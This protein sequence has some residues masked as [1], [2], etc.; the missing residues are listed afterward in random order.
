MGKGQATNKTQ[1]IQLFYRKI[2]K[3]ER[4]LA[5]QESITHEIRTKSEDYELVNRLN[6][7]VNQGASLPQILSQLALGTEK[8]FK[9]YGVNIYLLNRDGKR[10]VLQR[11][12]EIN[13]R[14]KQIASGFRI[15]IPD[16]IEIDVNK[17]SIHKRIL[18]AKK[19]RIIRDPGQITQIIAGFLKSKSIIKR[20]RSLVE[21]LKIKA[22]VW[23]PLQV[24]GKTIG[25]MD[26]SLYENVSSNIRNRIESIAAVVNSILKYAIINQRLKQSQQ[27]L[28]MCFDCACDIIVW[29]NA[30]GII[31]RI[32]DRV[33]DI[34][35]YR[36]E[37]FIGKNLSALTDIFE[38]DIGI[39]FK[40]FREVTASGKMKI[41]K[42]ANINISHMV[43]K[44][45]NGQEVHIEARTS[46]VKEAD[47]IIGY[48]SII[49]DMTEQKTMENALRT[50]E[51]LLRDFM[52]SANIGFVMFDREFNVTEVNQFIIDKFRLRKEDVIGKNMLDYSLG[53]MET[54]RLQMYQRVIDSGK[55]YTVEVITPDHLGLYRLLLK[56]FRLSNGI[57]MIVEFEEDSAGTEEEHSG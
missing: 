57:G 21:F 42:D 6:A 13:R 8:L 33:K 47:K 49:R 31:E 10:L 26:L 46:A 28:Q 5:A 11:N 3:F 27:E 29:I 37:E 39:L 25:L 38:Q 2:V 22:V 55:P 40:E 7:L 17:S 43:L 24:E 20:I 41:C 15:K 4:L 48:L 52:E 45:R 16:T 34:L 44:K 51:E 23:V 14:I 9:G 56:V 35:G 1:S 30:A 18:R 36:P 12:K 19:P 50:S 53:A 54:G 32:N